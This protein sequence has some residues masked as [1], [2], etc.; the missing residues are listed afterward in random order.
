MMMIILIFSLLAYQL[1]QHCNAR[2]NIIEE[3]N[4]YIYCDL[5]F[6][7]YIL[8]Y[9]V[10]CRPLQHISDVAIYD[11]QPGSSIRFR[12]HSRSCNQPGNDSYTLLHQNH[13]T[14]QLEI[15][16]QQ[17]NYKFVISDIQ[18]STS[19]VYCAYKECVPEDMEQC[20]MQIMG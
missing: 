11:V 13:H 7:A 9:T 5:I 1:L 4:M 12:S 6:I 18:L 16:S 2:G 19:G 15:V 10:T 14:G 3:T 20:C 17:R 8:E